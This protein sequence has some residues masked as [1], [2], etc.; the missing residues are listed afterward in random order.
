MTSLA[1][2]FRRRGTSETD[3]QRDDVLRTVRSV[4]ATLKPTADPL[5]ASDI[6]T[7]SDPER[8]KSHYLTVDQHL[9]QVA[10]LPATRGLDFACG[11]GL[12]TLIMRLMGAGRLAACDVHAAYV[13]NAVAV[14]SAA[15]AKDIEFKVNPI[16]AVPFPDGHFDWVTAIGLYANLNPGATRQL[17]AEIHRVIRPGGLFLTNDSA[18]PHHPEVRAHL[19]ERHRRAEIGDGTADA[20]TGPAFLSRVD[21][22]ARQAPDLSPEDRHAIAL[23]TCYLWGDEILDAVRA[24][25]EHG[26]WP[27]DRFDPSGIARPPVQADRGHAFGRPTDPLQMR[28]ELEAAGFAVRLRAPGIAGFVKDSDVDDVLKTRKSFFIVAQRRP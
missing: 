12:K 28:E 25:R 15:G 20:P 14:A 16:D 9:A 5:L 10:D 18:N 2:L 7:A 1:S 21:L 11:N 24:W 26:T 3:R 6:E 17:F 4:L 22:L 13:R 19:M 27:Q 8:L 23:G